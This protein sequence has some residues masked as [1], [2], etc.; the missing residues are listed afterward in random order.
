MLAVGSH[1]SLIYLAYALDLLVVIPSFLVTQT[2]PSTVKALDARLMM[3]TPC[4]GAT[5]VI[6]G[7][8]KAVHLVM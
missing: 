5:R 1:V 3:S 4:L 8:T 6:A 7:L 2:G